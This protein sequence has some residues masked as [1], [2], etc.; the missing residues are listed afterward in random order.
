MIYDILDEIY[1]TSG[2][3]SAMFTFHIRASHA[4]ACFIG[5]F[6]VVSEHDSHHLF[7]IPVLGCNV[8]M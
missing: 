5:S 4:L 8:L 2:W 1:L 6:R 3:M 7:Q